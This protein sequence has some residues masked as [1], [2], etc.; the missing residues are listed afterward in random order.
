MEDARSWRALTGTEQLQREGY[1]MPVCLCKAQD[2]AHTDT[3]LEGPALPHLNSFPLTRQ[4]ASYLGS[5]SS[6]SLISLSSEQ[7][8]IPCRDLGGNVLRGSWGV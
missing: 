6:I 5:V 2:G 7:L 4:H 1:S 3:A 8:P